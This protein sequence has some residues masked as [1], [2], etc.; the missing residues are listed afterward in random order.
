MK[1]RF[2]NEVAL[3]LMTIAN[4]VGREEFSGFGFCTREGKVITIYDF[5]LLDI[6]SYA[7]TEIPV[8]QM[9]PLL[10]RSDAGNMKVWIH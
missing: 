8:E 9:L 4:H 2:T 1:I 7:F 3:R 6:G 10:E 5:V